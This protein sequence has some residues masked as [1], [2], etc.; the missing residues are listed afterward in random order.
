MATVVKTVAFAAFLR[1]FQSSFDSLHAEYAMILS[2]LCAITLL[3]SNITAS[4]QTNVKRML[5]YS[6][7]S[8]AGFMLIAVFTKDAA[9][10]LLYYALVYSISSI[11]AFNVLKTVK[12]NS[13]GDE[14]LNAFKGL[15]KRNPFLAVTF[16]IALLSMAGIPPLAGF[17]A[18]YFMFSAAVSN[19][20]AWLVVIAIITSLIGV[21]YYFKIIINTFESQDTTNTIELPLVQKLLLGIC[22]IALLALSVYADCFLHLI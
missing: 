13:N 5:A 8:H 16:I 2:A 22:I 3:V 7:I 10:Y 1:L 17:M 18:K 9:N 6:S 19:G 14:S 15:L 20:Y 12:A 4:V 11:A 21:Y